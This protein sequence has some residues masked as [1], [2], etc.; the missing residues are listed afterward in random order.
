MHTKFNLLQSELTDGNRPLKCVSLYFVFVSVL[1]Y[2][3][4]AALNML[5]D[6]ACSDPLTLRLT[7]HRLFEICQY[8]PP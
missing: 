2:P 4:L 3:L 7:Q 6:Q 5:F 8:G 1:V